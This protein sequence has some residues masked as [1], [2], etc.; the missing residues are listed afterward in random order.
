MTTLEYIK[1]LKIQQCYVESIEEFNEIEEQINE[2][3][4]S[5]E[6]DAEFIKNQ[7]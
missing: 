2:L 1:E 6:A 7:S 5:L 3:I 4:D